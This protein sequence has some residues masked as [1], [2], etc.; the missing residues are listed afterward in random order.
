[1]QPE[2]LTLPDGQTPQAPAQPRTPQRFRLIPRFETD[3]AI[4]DFAQ[5]LKGKLVLLAIFALALSMLDARWWIKLA[6][7]SCMAFAP[8][9]RSL[10]LV[11]GT[12]LLTDILSFEGGL[13]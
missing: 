4:V 6:L 1:M 5:T 11:I 8:K 12:I 10:F 7:V 3:P 2:I 9:M 13:T